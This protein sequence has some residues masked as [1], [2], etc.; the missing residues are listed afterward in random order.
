MSNSP[1]AVRYPGLG[2]RLFAARNRAGLRR[3]AAATAADRSAAALAFYER[4]RVLPPVDV[5]R[6]LA[7]AYGVSLGYLLGDDDDRH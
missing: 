2:P 6:R 4:G 7:N 1:A 3:E 5:L